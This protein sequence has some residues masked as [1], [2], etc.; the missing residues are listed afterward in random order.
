MRP[1]R[2]E[3]LADYRHMLDDRWKLIDALNN[4][5][6]DSRTRSAPTRSSAA[7]CMPRNPRP[8]TSIRTIPTCTSQAIAYPMALKD[9]EDVDQAGYDQV[10]AQIGR[11][12]G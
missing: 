2:V 5:N 8:T 10:R 11:V 7:C 4:D 6:M 3:A 12:S 1:D 9:W